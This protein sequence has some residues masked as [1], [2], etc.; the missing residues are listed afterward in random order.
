[1]SRFLLYHRIKD[2]DKDYEQGKQYIIYQEID[3]L[4]QIT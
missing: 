3:C 4:F 1:M 2:K